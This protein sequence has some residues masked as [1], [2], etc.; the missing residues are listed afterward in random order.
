MYCNLYALH[1]HVMC[2]M[3]A[4]DEHPLYLHFPCMHNA[5][6]V[7]QSEGVCS[8]SYM[9]VLYKEN[10]PTW[11]EHVWNAKRE[12]EGAYGVPVGSM[13]CVCGACFNVVK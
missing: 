1:V 3:D 11:V 8:V 9:R 10:A 6:W 2:M 4:F 13:K 5:R 12:H 7:Q